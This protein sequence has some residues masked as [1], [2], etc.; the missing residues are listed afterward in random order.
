VEILREG[1]KKEVSIELTARPS[2]PERMTRNDQMSGGKLS[3]SKRRKDRIGGPLL[4]LEGICVGMN[5]ARAS[6]VATFAIPAHELSEIIERM[7]E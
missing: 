1:K 7:K 5:I 4:D 6:R 2:G 3:L